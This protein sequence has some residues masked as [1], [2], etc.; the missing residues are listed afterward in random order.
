M[1]V[2]LPAWVP[3]TSPLPLDFKWA[4]RRACLGFG[5]LLLVL[6]VWAY[7]DYERASYL[8][9]VRMEKEARERDAEYKQA[10]LQYRLEVIRL[11][12]M[13]GEPAAGAKPS[14]QGMVAQKP[15]AAL[16]LRHR[17]VQQQGRDD[18]PRG[19]AWKAALS[20]PSLQLHG[21]SEDEVLLEHDVHAV[22][23]P[24]AGSWM[25]HT[26]ALPPRTGGPGTQ[27][28]A[29]GLQSGPVPELRPGVQAWHLDEDVAP[30]TQHAQQAA[31]HV[32]RGRKRG[33]SAN[34]DMEGRGSYGEE[35]E[36][37]IAVSRR[38]RSRSQAS[39]MVVAGDVQQRGRGKRGRAAAT[40]ALE[41]VQKAKKR[42]KN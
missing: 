9:M 40:E 34:E 25:Q 8:L 2:P 42:G 5:A 17:L 3:F 11:A 37:V 30:S 16:E 33:A 21:V 4:V 1:Q 32:S 10:L 38:T 18:G 35:A 6:S 20:A 36:G 7:R 14:R 39:D 12:D 13:V 41:A 27:W 28:Q 15:G 22:G 26:P 31:P 24:G 29:A 19:K 23:V